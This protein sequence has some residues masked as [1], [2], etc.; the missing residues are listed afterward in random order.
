MK[1]YYAPAERIDEQLLRSQIKTIDSSHAMDI[2]LQAAPDL[3]LAINSH[4]QVVALNKAFAE[5]LG[6]VDLEKALGLR[7]GEVL[8]CKYAFDEP[9]GCGTTSY[10]S[11]CGAAVAMM[12]AID[13]DSICERIC[14]LKTSK[15]G[16]TVDTSL[17][18]RSQPVIVD[19]NRFV[20]I[21]AR[22]ITQTQLDNME[23]NFMQ[24]MSAML[25]ASKSYGAFIQYESP[26]N[27]LL[28]RLN[29]MIDR[30]L[31]E[32]NLQ[33]M[34]KLH[35]HSAPK[36]NFEQVSLTSIRNMVFSVVINRE[37]KIGKSIKEEGL[38]KNLCITT[39]P[40]LASRVIISML[41]NALEDTKNGENIQLSITV[42]NGKVT[43]Q[44]WNKS[45]MPEDIQLRVFQRYFSTKAGHG[46]GHGT[47]M[48]KYLG[49]KCLGGKVSFTST[50]EHGTI[51]S[52]TLPI[53]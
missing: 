11:S 26:D 1:S 4:R 23:Y 37:F 2:V 15:N 43:W 46:R 20:L 25:N 45:Y 40:I 17:Y 48:M 18:V 12:A 19:G 24:N 36:A 8:H 31:Q 32:I 3:L 38:N 9:N 28:Q 16:V 42:G 39:D 51:F 13:D 44:V 41:Q 50:M 30:T 27:V 52:F 14:A 35:S 10:C 5:S 47:Y 34:L 6:I 7:F 49:E 22:D 53:Q 33:S 21:Y 29:M